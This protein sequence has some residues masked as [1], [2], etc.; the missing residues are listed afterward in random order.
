M[1]RVR[2]QSNGKTEVIEPP[3]GEETEALKVGAMRIA[4]ALARVIEERDWEDSQSRSE[5]SGS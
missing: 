5:A 2:L 1:V 4:E 3:T